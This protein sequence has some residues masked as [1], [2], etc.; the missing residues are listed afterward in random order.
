MNFFQIF[1]KKSPIPTLNPSSSSQAFATDWMF[2]RK[3]VALSEPKWAAIWCW[4]EC[5]FPGP[6]ASAQIVPTNSSEVNTTI[7]LCFFVFFLWRCAKGFLP[8]GARQRGVPRRM[9]SLLSS[10]DGIT[11]KI[12][13]KFFNS[14]TIQ[15]KK[16]KASKKWGS[17]INFFS[18]QLLEGFRGGGVRKS[19]PVFKFY[20][21]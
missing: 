21:A 16:D 15:W 1:A 13:N 3:A 10:V 12:K 4:S 6:T 2:A 8:P 14:Y 17:E 19:G 7:T 18:F 11:I 5:D 9:I 20:K